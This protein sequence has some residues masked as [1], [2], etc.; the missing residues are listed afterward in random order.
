[1]MNI[2]VLS[3]KNII[4]TNFALSTIMLS[5]LFCQEYSNDSIDKKQK[6]LNEIDSEIIS[7]EN[8]LK[9]EINN[10]AESEQKIQFIN[11]NIKKELV[12]ISEKRYEKE[13]KQKLLDNA[14]LILD[15]LNL[16]L[17]NI[18]SSKLDV[19]KII[20]KLNITNKEIDYKIK[21]INDSIKI[22]NKKHILQA[23]FIKN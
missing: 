22:V 8:K 16:D 12:N 3:I 17:Q 21:V 15:S 20:N 9:S 2:I 1:M 7:L 11:D 10:A 5:V 14:S 19:E 4:K 18:K 13:Q 23:F 6:S